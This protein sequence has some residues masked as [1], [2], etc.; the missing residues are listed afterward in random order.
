MIAAHDLG[1]S[2][3]AFD[4]IYRNALGEARPEPVVRLRAVA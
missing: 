4:A 3:D 2:L 1:A